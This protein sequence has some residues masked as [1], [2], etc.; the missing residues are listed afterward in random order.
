[1]ADREDQ[2]L[3]LQ[4][5]IHEVN[6]VPAGTETDPWPFVMIANDGHHETSVQIHE[7]DG[8]KLAEFLLRHLSDSTVAA[9]IATRS[10][11][12]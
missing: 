5:I 9:L 1:M 4:G 2:Y 8:A 10:A 3:D 11:R 12:P 7:D 6:L